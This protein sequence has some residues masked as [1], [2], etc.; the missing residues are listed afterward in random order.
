MRKEKL[1]VLQPQLNDVQLQ[2]KWGKQIFYDKSQ[3]F[4]NPVIKTI[5]ST[6]EKSL[7]ESRLTKTAFEGLI[8]TIAYVK[9]IEK[10]R[11]KAKLMR[12]YLDIWKILAIGEK[13]SFDFIM[14][15]RLIGSI[16][17][18]N[19]EFFGDTLVWKDGV[20]VFMLKDDLLKFII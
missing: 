1:A 17:K 6:I 13:V 12:I 7:K 15:H 14:I 18:S 2:E 4:C 19:G 20:R 9:A 3:K 8:G 16:L 5:K 10:V 11:K